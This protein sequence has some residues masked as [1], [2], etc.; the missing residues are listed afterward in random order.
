MTRPENPGVR[1]PPPTLFVAGI[2]GGLA[3][4][5]V[6]PIAIDT[7]LAPSV[8]VGV[9]W[10]CVVA[11]L[12]VLVWAM[13]TFAQAHTAIYPNQPASM[14]VGHGPYRYSRN[15]MYVGLTALTCGIGVLLANVW[16]L[17][18]LPVVLIALTVFVIRREEAYLASAFGD[19]YARYRDEVRRWL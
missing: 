19:G 12:G 16:I 5:R 8:R 18:L 9:G 6:I 1:F 11:G 15:P 7:L 13:V 17:A 2:A 10:A 3:L 14:V 4:Q